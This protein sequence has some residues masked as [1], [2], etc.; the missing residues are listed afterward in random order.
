MPVPRLADGG[1]GLT[2]TKLGLRYLL[3]SVRR[4]DSRQRL[5]ADDEAALAYIRQ[6]LA[7]WPETDSG[8]RWAK[9]PPAAAGAAA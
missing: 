1:I 7:A 2:Y 4:H 5:P 8:R 6:W 3:C 9:P